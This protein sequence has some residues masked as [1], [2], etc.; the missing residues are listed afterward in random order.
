MEY[1]ETT[2]FVGYNLLNEPWVGDAF[3]DPRL[4][5][6]ATWIR[7]PRSPGGTLEPRSKTDPHC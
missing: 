3:A 1:V 2:N 6:I 5:L 4:L 7:G